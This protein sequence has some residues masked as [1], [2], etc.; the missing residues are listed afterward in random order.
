MFFF[1]GGTGAAASRDGHSCL[2]F[3]SNISNTPIEIMET[4]APVRIL[5]KRLLPDSGGAGEFRGGLGQ[6][7]T[8]RNLSARPISASFLAERTRFAAPGL[9]GGKAGAPGR[10]VIGDRTVDPKIT[11]IVEPGGVIELTMPGGGGFG[12]PGRRT[13]ARR[14]ED[15][16]AGYVTP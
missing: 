11:H 1:N 5:E 12:D 4:T 2:T 9:L 3:P 15:A 10:V 14:R 8:L 13:A 6:V 16:A 7:V